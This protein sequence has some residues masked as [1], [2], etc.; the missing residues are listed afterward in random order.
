MVLRFIDF[1]VE[2]ITDFNFDSSLYFCKI[3]GGI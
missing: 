2:N 3:R 1:G